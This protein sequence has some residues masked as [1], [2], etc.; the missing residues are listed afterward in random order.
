M[1]RLIPNPAW[2]FAIENHVGQKAHRALANRRS[3]AASQMITATVNENTRTKIRTRLKSNAWAVFSS[4]ESFA[5]ESDGGNV[6]MKEKQILS[7]TG[8]GLI[9]KVL[10]SPE[11]QFLAGLGNEASKDTKPG[12]VEVWDILSGKPVFVKE[13]HSAEVTCIAYGPDG[14]RLAS[15]SEDGTVVIR[16]AS[17][18]KAL[19]ADYRPDLG[20]EPPYIKVCQRCDWVEPEQVPSDKAKAA[21]HSAKLAASTHA[22][23]PRKGLKR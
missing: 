18:G 8:R 11:G 4:S 21:N 17:T 12:F 7:L 9:E 15:G 3:Q 22:R 14:K 2:P 1:S 20:I 6:A 13:S 5:F 23:S 19:S 10:F 16:D